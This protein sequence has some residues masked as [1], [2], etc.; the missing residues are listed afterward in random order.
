MQHKTYTNNITIHQL[1]IIICLLLLSSCTFTSAAQNTRTFLI[2]IYHHQNGIKITDGYLYENEYYDLEVL[3]AQ[4]KTI[5]Y[6]VIVTTPWNTTITTQ[7]I[8]NVC[9]RAP[10]YEIYPQ[11][12]I[13]ISK[14]NYQSLETT[15]FVLK[16]TLTIVTTQ[17]SVKEYEQF[18]VTIHDQNNQKIQGATVTINSPNAAPATTNAQGKALLIAPETDTTKQFLITAFKEGYKPGSNQIQI[19]ASSTALLPLD[20]DKIYI[21]C[22]LIILFCAVIFVK[23]R[24]RRSTT[25]LSQTQTI[26]QNY[27]PQIH[28]RQQKLNKNHSYKQPR[29]PDTQNHEKIHVH[30]KGAKIEEIRIQSAD[31][32]KETKIITAA[33]NK[34]AEQDRKKDANEWFTGTEYM[35]YKL[36]E[37]TGKIDTQ[38][39]GKWFEGVDSIKLK[40]DEKLKQNYKKKEIK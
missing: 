13:T 2:N 4:T 3:D 1:F 6:N 29:T 23:I 37:M 10:N 28:A 27:D 7:A 5:L 8:P 12:I 26:N 20:S 16:G 31:Q 22:A 21:I 40:V 39:T 25:E 35:R 30:E 34:P 19:E 17:E 33:N 11:F 36:D 24:Q 14:E 32:K 38:T 15:I 18:Q 9:I